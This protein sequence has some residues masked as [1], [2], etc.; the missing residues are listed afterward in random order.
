MSSG[1]RPPERVGEV[2]PVELTG[3]LEAGGDEQYGDTQYGDE[4]YRD[5]AVGGSGPGLLER[6]LGGWWHS[7]TPRRRRAGAVLVT[8]ALAVAVGVP[9]LLHRPPQPPPP[10]PNDLTDVQYLGISTGGGQASRDFTITILVG[11]T[12]TAPLTVRRIV[13]GYQGISLSVTPGLPRTARPGQ[14]LTLS[15]RATVHDC[16]VVPPDD[17]YPVLVL[18]VS[19]SRSPQTQSD[20]LGVPY[21]LAMH[22][23]L[24]RACRGT[25]GF[26]GPFPQ[27][28][29]DRGIF[30]P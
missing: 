11:D 7:L 20:A 1:K 5:T 22:G 14:P 3:E 16:S 25:P 8:L 26:G 27:D 9:V 28:A 19:D 10:P 30:P 18:T 23:A 21:I 15:L 29:A 4:P 17:A 2:G 13:Q 6:R 24:L 12:G